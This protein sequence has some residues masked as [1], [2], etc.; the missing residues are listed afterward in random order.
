M[1][2]GPETTVHETRTKQENGSV[3][4][5]LIDPNTGRVTEQCIYLKFA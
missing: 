5:W 1:T 3:G 4:L 2:V